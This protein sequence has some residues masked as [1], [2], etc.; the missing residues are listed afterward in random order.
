VTTDHV[1]D[2]DLFAQE[3]KA[4]RARVIINAIGGAEAIEIALIDRLALALKVGPETATGMRAFIPIEP[5]PAQPVVNG[6]RGFLGV[7]GAVGI[8][9]A[10]DKSAASVFRVEPVKQSGARAAD[11]EIASGRRCETNA[12]I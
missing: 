5:E 7:A 2:D 6:L 1:I 4:D 12:D 3:T 11:M 10:Q 9:D 8:L